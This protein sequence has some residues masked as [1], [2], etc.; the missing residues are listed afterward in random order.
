MKTPE[1]IGQLVADGLKKSAREGH[2]NPTSFLEEA[3]LL[4]V[5]MSIPA[6]F[7][8]EGTSQE[9]RG[10]FESIREPLTKIIR[11]RLEEILDPGTTKFV[12]QGGEELDEGWKNRVVSLRF[13]EMTRNRIFFRIGIQLLHPEGTSMIIPQRSPAWK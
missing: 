11:A 12:K 6:H 10:Q 13:W 1:E 7:V 9:A 3:R 8:F 5:L 4:G 2:C